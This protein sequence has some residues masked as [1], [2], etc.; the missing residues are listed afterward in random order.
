MAP[1]PKRVL[2][3][4]SEGVSEVIGYLL[5]FGILSMVLVLAM[6]AFSVGQEAAVG[7]AVEL[8]AESAAA[9]VAG[10]VV[11][12][13]VLAEQQGTGI[14]VAYLVDL[15]QQLEGRDYTV[16]L[17]RATTVDVP[18]DCTRGAHPDQVCVTVPSLGIDPAIAPIFSAGA[19]TDVGVC[20]T[21]AP[22][23]ALYVRFYSVPPSGPFSA[24]ACGTDQLFL[25][26]S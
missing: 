18:A 24:N 10:V 5:T 1:D 17:E 7:R 25:E 11:Q 26:A 23:G 14:S 22:G 9:R 12:T 20:N 15:P 4:D 19:A 21:E 8:R 3:G 2:R 13:A 16:R 6:S